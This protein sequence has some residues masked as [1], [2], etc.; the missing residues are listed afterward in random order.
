MSNHENEPSNDMSE[1][2]DDIDR[3]LEEYRKLLNSM[4]RCAL[5]APERIDE[6]RKMMRFSAAMLI[7]NNP[8]FVQDFRDTVKDLDQLLES[9]QP[10][11]VRS[12]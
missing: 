9:A 1:D 8:E 12:I 5:E 6:L 2:Q 7:S 3:Y 4:A 11:R 10:K